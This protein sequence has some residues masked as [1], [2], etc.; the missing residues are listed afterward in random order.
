MVNHVSKLEQEL[1]TLKTYAIDH[2]LLIA[3]FSELETTHQ[4]TAAKAAE[5][6]IELSESKHEAGKSIRAH[7][8]L[9]LRYTR[10]THDFETANERSKWMNDSLQ[11]Q[12]RSAVGSLSYARDNLA[13]LKKQL[14]NLKTEF[15]NSSQEVFDSIKTDLETRMYTHLPSLIES[16]TNRRV[17][18]SL[19]RKD[20]M[21]QSMKEQIGDLKTDLQDADQRYADLLLE[22]NNTTEQYEEFL[23]TN[24][25]VSAE[26]HDSIKAECDALNEQIKTTPQDLESRISSLQASKEDL[27]RT[28]TEEKSNTAK[29]IGIL[30]C[31][32]QENEA[33][34]QAASLKFQEER[35]A[36]ETGGNSDVV[37]ANRA[38]AQKD[39]ELHKLLTNMS[40][41]KT[42]VSKMRDE[43]VLTIEA[44]Q[45]RVKQLQD[46]Y[47]EM[48]KDAKELG[49]NKMVDKEQLA[50]LKAKMEAEQIELL[51]TQKANFQKQLVE[52]Q[53]K[54]QSQVDA[55]RLSRDQSALENKRK[56]AAAEESSRDQMVKLKNENDQLKTRLVALE[57]KATS[58]LS[59]PDPTTSA[60]VHELESHLSKREAEIV[61]LKETVKMECEERM[62]L[63]TR[64]DALERGVGPR[65]KS[66][67]KDA[68]ASDAG[69]ANAGLEAA[70]AQ[71]GVL[72]PVEKG[73]TSYQKLMAM[74]NVKK[75]QKL[76]S[77]AKKNQM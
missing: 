26:E 56:L 16:E 8:E 28:L 46:K 70:V 27:E 59:Q 4:H 6:E 31:A 66:R 11:S 34:L 76:R 75:E 60:R 33:K 55:A 48:L 19:A 35:K 72:V 37:K 22:M 63:L 29:S 44:H 25:S 40:E 41:L 1:E 65:M 69:Q 2:P 74:A 52:V 47:Q 13:Y 49:S 43:R 68:L 5:L 32:I 36:W 64:V 30:K 57:L 77:A 73:P 58:D 10:L 9:Q 12:L 18:T 71:A 3:K 24:R 17:S 38:L 53:K 50:E 23:R 51:T 54:L 62:E 15:Q 7:H 61:F 20:D 42:T 45:S 21:M 39:L 67:P 14:G